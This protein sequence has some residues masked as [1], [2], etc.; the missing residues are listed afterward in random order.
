M[1][2]L[3]VIG[4]ISSGRLVG[5]ELS[6]MSAQGVIG[7]IDANED[8]PLGITRNETAFVHMKQQPVPKIGPR[9]G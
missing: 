1:K 3:I 7:A 8:L 5:Q 6:L 9:R 2:K 4:R